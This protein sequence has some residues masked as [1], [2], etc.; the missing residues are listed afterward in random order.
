MNQLQTLVDVHVAQLPPQQ[1]VCAGGGAADTQL[2]L[3]VEQLVAATA[4]QIGSFSSTPPSP[5]AQQQPAAAASSSQHNGQEL[6]QQQQPPAVQLPQPWA[7]GQGEVEL[8][9]VLA[10]R[11][12]CACGLL[13]SGR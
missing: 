7:R 13:P 11:R 6:K 10:Q 12:R 2:V 5:S 4:G 8:V 9:G 3:S 1:L